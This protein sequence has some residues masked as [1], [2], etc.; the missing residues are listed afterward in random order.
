MIVFGAGYKFYRDNVIIPGQIRTFLEGLVDK[1]RPK[2][3][4]K[5]I[6]PEASRTTKKDSEHS[7]PFAMVLVCEDEEFRKFML[8]VQ[9]FAVNDKLAFSV[10][11]FDKQIVSWV[12]VNFVGDAVEEG[13]EAEALAAIKL[14]V[15][16]ATSYR[17]F[18]TEKYAAAGL[19]GTTSEHVLDSTKSWRLTF[20]K[21]YRED[22]RPHHVFQ[23]TGKPWPGVTAA[24]QSRLRKTIKELEI[25]CE[26]SGEPPKDEQ[27]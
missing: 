12:I 16:G 22:G 24:D 3:P 9:T 13:N 21:N 4:M 6:R 8:A 18:V 2:P 1:S 20:V 11:P 15:W 25:F 17:L 27:R 26:V 5:L 7:P 14:K 10:V 23:L 19:H